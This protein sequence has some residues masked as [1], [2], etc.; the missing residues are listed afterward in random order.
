[1]LQEVLL[2]KSDT[3]LKSMTD[4]WNKISRNS[5]NWKSVLSWKPDRLTLQTT[6]VLPYKLTNSR[7]SVLNRGRYSVCP[8]LP[9]S[10]GTHIQNVRVCQYIDSSNFPLRFRKQP[11]NY[12][13][14][15]WLKIALVSRKEIA[16]RKP[17]FSIRPDSCLPSSG[18]L[19]IVDLGGCGSGN[20]LIPEFAWRVW[21]T[22]RYS[23]R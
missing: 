4:F 11:H 8:E 6:S 13:V 16:I 17:L 9:S 23:S 14:E 21:G 1:M 20:G 3:K 18:R 15:L 22:P 5:K 19:C 7:Y 2:D 12:S 10:C